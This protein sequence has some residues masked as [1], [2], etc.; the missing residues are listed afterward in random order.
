MAKPDKKSDKK[1]ATK[2]AEKAPEKAPKNDTPKYGIAELA[3]AMG[4]E[5]ASA[6]VKLRAA[7]IEKNGGRYG[8]DT[9]A[10]LQEVVSKLGKGAAKKAK[11]AKDEDEDDEDEDLDD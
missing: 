4:V 1:T 9:K 7:G 6:R 11:K 10:E 3:E 5:P 2:A 8:W